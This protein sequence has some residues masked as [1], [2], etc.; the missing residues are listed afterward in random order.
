ME[1]IKENKLNKAHVMRDSSDSA[2]L[3]ISVGLQQ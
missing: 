1:E 3:V 2:T